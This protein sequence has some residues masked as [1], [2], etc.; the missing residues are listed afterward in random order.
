M[1]KIALLLS[2]VIGI[3]SCRNNNAPDVSHIKVD[4]KIK[5]FD[6]AFFEKMDTTQVAAHLVMLTQQFPRFTYD[7]CEYMIGA[8][9][10]PQIDSSAMALYGM[11]KFYQLSKPIYDSIA[12]KFEDMSAI[13]DDLTQ[14]FKYVK[15][16]LPNYQIPEVVTYVGPFDL[17]GVAVTPSAMA[18][19]LQLFAGKNF[20]FYQSTEAQEVFPLYISRRFEPAYIAPACMNSVIQDVYP[21]GSAGES[22]I[23]QIIEKGKRWYLLDKFLSNAP[24]NI[25]TGYTEKQL[26]WCKENEGMIWGSLLQSTDIY[27]SEPAIIKNYIGE[28]PTTDGMPAASPGNIGQWIGWQMV[29][30]YVSKHPEVTV[31][32]LMKMDAKKI[33]TEGK[34][35]PK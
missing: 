12:P 2:V 18:I 30:L 33:F 35:K 7:F 16:Y 1:K 21:D 14:A 8:P 31:D 5:R 28:S 9:L 25:K 6:K 17:P 32:A 4:I 34:Y 10:T 26:K 20:S 15:Y 24:D 19:G 11:K 29:K 13:E 22:L 3:Y 23:V 27:T